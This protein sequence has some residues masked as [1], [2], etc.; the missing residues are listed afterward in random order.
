MYVRFRWSARHSG[1][2]GAREFRRRLTDGPPFGSIP[3]TTTCLPPVSLRCA[4]VVRCL[5]TPEVR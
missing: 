4:V 5:I 1:D 2:F 3:L